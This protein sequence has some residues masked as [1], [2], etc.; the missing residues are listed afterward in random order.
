[1]PDAAEVTAGTDP[2]RAASVLKLQASAPAHANSMVLAW[3]SVAGRTYA[4]QYKSTV[5][6]GTWQTLTNNLQGTG[7]SMQVSDTISNAAVR[8]YRLGVV[9]N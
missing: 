4:I 9:K 6:G 1:M 2:T 3:P 7:G 8:F 5:V